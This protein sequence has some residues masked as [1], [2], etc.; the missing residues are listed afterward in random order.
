VRIALAPPVL[1]NESLQPLAAKPIPVPANFEHL[2]F[3]DEVGLYHCQRILD[4][5]VAHLGSLDFR[6]GAARR[7]GLHR[8]SGQAGI[9][10]AF[11]TSAARVIGPAA[12]E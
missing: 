12:K 9:S 1:T 7:T 3:R 10:T 4:P 5:L 2:R 8:L 6:G 11:V